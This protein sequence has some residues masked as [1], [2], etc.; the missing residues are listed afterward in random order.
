MVGYWGGADADGFSNYGVVDQTRQF[1]EGILFHMPAFNQDWWGSVFGLVPAHA[2][3]RFYDDYHAG[4][5][6]QG[7]DGVKVDSQAVLEG[8]AQKQGGRVPLTR[9]YRAALESSARRHFS[10]RLINCM[11]HAQETW[12]GSSDSTLIRSSVDFF[13]QRPESHGKH[14]Y[15]NAQVG[16]WFGEFMHPDWD[17]FQSGHEWGAFHA[18]GRAVSGGPVYVSDKPGEH[19]FPLLKKL[20]CSDGSVLLCDG[21]GVPTRDLLCHDPTREALLLKIWNT[22]GKAGVIGVFNVQVGAN[23]KP[24]PVLEGTL[25]PSDVPGLKGTVFACYRQVAGTLS[26]LERESCVSL[27]LGERGYELF[28]LVPIENGFAPIGLIDKLNSAAAISRVSFPT[29]QSCELELRD[30]GEFLAYCE[31]PPTR[32]SVAGRPAVFR[33]EQELRSLRFS[34]ASSGPHAV[35]INW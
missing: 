3:A 9:A 12:Y 26:S 18:A 29:A 10:G 8:V 5:R 35:S 17:M 1:G 27:S 31:Q 11:S 7:V 19:D 33:Y 2:I 25:R 23:G 6:A 16:L 24:G 22:A 32:V 13:P 4:L 20:V 14:L 30:G 15:I 21:V 28:T 34:S